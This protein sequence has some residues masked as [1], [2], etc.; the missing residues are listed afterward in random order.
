M[1]DTGG[2]ICAFQLDPVKELAQPPEALKPRPPGRLWLHFNL[3]DTRARHF[4]EKYAPLPEEPRQLMLE[5]DARI[6]L[7]L[8][9]EGFVAVLGDLH[10]DFDSDPEGFGLIRVYVDADVMISGR[11]HPLRSVDRLRRELQSPSEIESPVELFEQLIQQLAETVSDVSVKLSD[12]VEDAED[13]ILAGRVEDH[14]ALLAR[15]R[16]SLARLRRQVNANRNALL[17]LGTRMQGLFN[18]EQRQ[19]LRE[20]IEHLDAVG[21]D[22]ELVTERARLLQEEIAARLGE[23]T[24]RNLYVLSIVTTAMLPI[25]LITGIFGMNVRGL[26]FAQ[27]DHGFWLVMAL[28]G[29]TLAATRSLLKRIGVL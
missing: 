18:S 23:A 25:T 28:M 19:R 3:S 27:S 15:V 11:V 29:L 13:E 7:Q 1:Q 5:H 22:L 14:G 21:Q 10:H 20:A 26:P 8:F 17:P 24:N 9:P 16:R 2:L 4:I 12:T 6:H